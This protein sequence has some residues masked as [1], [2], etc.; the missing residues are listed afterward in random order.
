MSPGASG[1]VNTQFM[2]NWSSQPKRVFL[3]FFFYQ[4]ET[5]NDRRSRPT[6]TFRCNVRRVY[7]LQMR[8]RGKIGTDVKPSKRLPALPNSVPPSP[9]CMY[10]Q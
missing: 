4:A 7:A 10:F 3:F 8:L 5:C 2:H 6:N 9:P 1:R